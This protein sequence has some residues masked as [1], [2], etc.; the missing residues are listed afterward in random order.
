MFIENV[1]KPNTECGRTKLQ[2]RL[3]GAPAYLAICATT[4]RYSGAH[5]GNTWMFDAHFNNECM[6]NL[7]CWHSFKARCS[8]TL[9]QCDA[10]Q[11]LAHLILITGWRSLSQRMY[12]YMHTF[13]SI[14]ARTY[15][16]I[17]SLSTYTRIWSFCLV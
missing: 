7:P 4:L 16:H 6:H 9:A 2:W 15:T 5:V 1:L 3:E 8:F 10:L 13:I 14:R 11:S 17:N 12:T